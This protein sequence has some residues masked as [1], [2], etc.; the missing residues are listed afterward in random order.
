MRTLAP[1]IE[2]RAKSFV[3]RNAAPEKTRVRTPS[4]D[5]RCDAGAR[6]DGQHLGPVRLGTKGT[7]SV[8]G[9]SSRAQVPADVEGVNAIANCAP[10]VDP[11]SLQ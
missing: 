8:T 4:L 1:T 10:L 3:E 2:M 9:R 6:D 7:V 5:G 11:A